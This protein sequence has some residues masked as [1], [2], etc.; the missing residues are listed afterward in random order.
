MPDTPGSL[1][2]RAVAA[3]CLVLTVAGP[4]AAQ[5]PAPPPS[6]PDFMSRY[7]FHLSANTLAADDPRYL[8]DTR[9]GG[10][11]DIVD[12]VTG[13]ASVLVD[14]QVILGDELRAFDPNQ[15]YYVLE[16]SASYRTR[17]AEIAG[18][19]HHVSRHLSD[20]DKRFPI[21]WNIIGAR[22]LRRFEAG[23]MTFDAYGGG[24]VVS[25]YANVDYRWTA[26]V[27]VA[28]RRAVGSRVGLFANG[29]GEVFGVD[30]LVRRAGVDGAL[31]TRGSQTGGRLEAG[32]RFSGPGGA[33][34]LF[35]GVERRIDPDPAQ[36]PARRWAIAGFRL[37]SR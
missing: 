22:A 16:A 14:Y 2:R 28:V 35:A 7:D 24:G 17:F 26:D 13:R 10:D 30:G 15:S 18:V 8:W 6:S 4:S 25:A 31:V 33:I 19:F 23:G 11:L 1:M 5:S 20:R 36:S 21:A 12:W 37:A 3:A 29:H 27:D 32:V 9:F 34:E